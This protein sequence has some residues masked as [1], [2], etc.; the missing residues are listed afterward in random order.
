MCHSFSKVTQIV[1][2]LFLWFGRG[3]YDDDY[4]NLTCNMAMDKI[5]NHSNMMFGKKGTCDATHMV[6]SKA[7]IFYLKLHLKMSSVFIVTRFYVL[8]LD[9]HCKLESS[10]NFQF[11]SCQKVCQCWL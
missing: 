7:S 3:V 2:F 8:V 4:C 11:F 9:F 6:Y 1:L 10:S 5:Q